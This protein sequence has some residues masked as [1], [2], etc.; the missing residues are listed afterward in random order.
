LCRQPDPCT[1]AKPWPYS[2]RLVDRLAVSDVVEL[3]I[4]YREGYPDASTGTLIYAKAVLTAES[5]CKTLKFADVSPTFPRDS[6]A[7]Q[8]LD[9]DQVE[10]YVLLGQHIGRRAGDLAMPHIRRLGED[11]VGEGTVPD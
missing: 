9:P 11:D 1:L 6:T 2:G 8:F 10:H 3:G 4:L 7:D 5:P